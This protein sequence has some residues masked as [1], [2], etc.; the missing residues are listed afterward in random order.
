MDV[1]TYFSLSDFYGVNRWKLAWLQLIP[2]TKMEYETGTVP[3]IFVS[4]IPLCLFLLED[5]TDS[6]SH[7]KEDRWL[8]TFC[9]FIFQTDLFSGSSQDRACLVGIPVSFT[10][11]LCDRGEFAF[12]L[13]EE[14][15]Q[16]VC[17]K[18]YVLITT[19]NISETKHVIV[20]HGAADSYSLLHIVLE[21][22]ICDLLC[23]NLRDIHSWTKS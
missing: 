7:V 23:H 3:N 14:Q 1:F 11:E 5:N 4:E 15:I 13:P 16:P 22:F 20:R 2:C 10:F 19:S 8:R 17:E 18:V 21:Q 6:C 9:H 12:E